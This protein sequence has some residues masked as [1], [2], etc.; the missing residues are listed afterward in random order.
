MQVAA[1]FAVNLLVSSAFRADHP[2]VLDS[3]GPT[4]D[5]ASSNDPSPSFAYQLAPKLPALFC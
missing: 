2:T 4:P 5:L 1:I 3:F